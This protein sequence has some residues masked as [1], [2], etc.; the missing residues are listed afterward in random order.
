MSAKV[1]PFIRVRE[2]RV[3]WDMGRW[4]VAL[5]VR[6]RMRQFFQGYA[7]QASAEHAAARIRRL[8]RIPQVHRR[9]QESGS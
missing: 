5:F 9:E 7:S 1:L 4:R 2:I 8:E 3:D 6:G